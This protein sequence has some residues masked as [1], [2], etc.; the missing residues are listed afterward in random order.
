MAIDLTLLSRSYCH[1]CQEMEVA[2]A[3]LAEEFGALVTVLEV[4]SDAQLEAR[5]D[6]LVPVLLHGESE[7]CH[8]FLDEAKTREYLAGIR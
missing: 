4:D 1:L 2:L 3:P 8:Y 7:I 5:Y 6:E